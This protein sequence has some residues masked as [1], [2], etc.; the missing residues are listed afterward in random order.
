MELVSRLKDWL[1]RKPVKVEYTKGEQVAVWLFRILMGSAI[2][3][4]VFSLLAFDGDKGTIV[5]V[6]S[7][8]LFMVFFTFYNF[9]R[10]EALER[11]IR[12]TRGE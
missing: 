6:C 11:E 5:S 9:I 1:L 12:K 8:G 3:F 2:A 10:I 4:F 7:A